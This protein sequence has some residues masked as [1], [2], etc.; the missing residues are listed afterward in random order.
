MACYRRS[1]GIRQKYC[2]IRILLDLQHYF[3][4]G[5]AIL[6]L[7]QAGT[8]CQLKRLGYIAGA[9]WEQISILFFD[10]IPRDSSVPFSPSGCLP[11]AA[12]PLADENLTDWICPL[13][14]L[15][16]SCS[17]HVQAFCPVLAVFLAFYYTTNRRKCPVVQ[18]FW[19]WSV[20]IK[21]KFNVYRK[22]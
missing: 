5:K 9:R 18:Y 19:G 10:F 3:F 22:I 4:V 13:L 7:N 8:Q 12:Y 16:H 6:P 20:D 17:L 21:Y 14:Y 11:A 1:P 15:L 2:K